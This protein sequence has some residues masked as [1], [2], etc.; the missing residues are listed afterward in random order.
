MKKL[1]CVLIAL[2][3]MLSLCACAAGDKRQNSGQVLAQ[4]ELT[5]EEEDVLS[6]LGAGKSIVFD[7]KVG[8]S[9]RTVRLERYEL[10]ADGGWTAMGGGSFICGSTSGRIALSMDPDR[11]EI[12]FAIQDE[13][14]TSAVKNN[15][16]VSGFVGM[17]VAT[18]Y[19]SNETDITPDQEIPLAVQILTTQ[20]ETHSYAPDYFF[21]PEEYAQHGYEHVYAVTITFSEDGLN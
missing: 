14:G 7:Y 21:H 1:L 15:Y 11:N 20:N 12:R 18:S 19:V 2:I 5:Q 9:I 16:P 10:N 8:E 17:S 6:L 4:A 13:H 3:L